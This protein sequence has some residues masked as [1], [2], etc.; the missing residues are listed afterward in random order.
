MVVDSQGVCEVH[1]VELVP[2]VVAPVPAPQPTVITSWSWVTVK[3]GSTT[4]ERLVVE[5]VSRL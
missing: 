1:S 5:R 3:R 4:W 2:V